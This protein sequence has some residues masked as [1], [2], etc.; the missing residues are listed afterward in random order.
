M[1]T[2][3]TIFLLFCL[4][5]FSW[6]T[7]ASADYS[8]QGIV[9]SKNMLSGATVTAINGFQ[10]TATVPAN[11]TVSVKFSQDKVNYYNSAGVKE[12]WDTCANGVTNVNLTG[13]AWTG[14]IL[15]YKIQLTSTDVA[16]TPTISDAQVDY[17]GTVVPA[18]SG[19]SYPTQGAVVSTNLLTGGTMAFDNTVRFAYNV[20]S[21]PSG[22]S[23]RVY[24]VGRGCFVFWGA[25][26]YYQLT[27]FVGFELEWGDQFLLQIK[28]L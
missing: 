25:F 7:F 5:L 21:L 15:F 18:L 9:E 12:G 10:V 20:S 4:T 27:G 17:D 22:T 23:A 28:S 14:G 2:K 1:K 11:T 24:A 13:L 19:N 16:V 6:A 8:A 26:G 3:F